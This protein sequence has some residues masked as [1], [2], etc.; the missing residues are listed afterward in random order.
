MTAFEWRYTEA[1]RR[2]EELIAGEPVALVN[3]RWYWTRRLSARIWDRH[4]AGGQQV[5]QS[6][7]L[8]DANPRPGRRG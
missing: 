5:D 6:I 2:A 8:L 7:H 1:Y 4:L 3:L